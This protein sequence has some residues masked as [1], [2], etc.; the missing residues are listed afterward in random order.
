M[1]DI[2][3]NELYEAFAQASEIV[4]IYVCDMKRDLSRWSENAVD[5]FNLPGEY[6][7]NAGEMWTQQIPRPE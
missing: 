6:I 1:K 3:N 7:Q 5:Y 2:L 4:Y